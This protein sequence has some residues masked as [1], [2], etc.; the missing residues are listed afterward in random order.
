M[1]LGLGMANPHLTTQVASSTQSPKSI[2]RDMTTERPKRPT[3]HYEESLLANA[4]LNTERAKREAQ[5]GKSNAGL[6][7]EQCNLIYLVLESENNQLKVC[8]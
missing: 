3:V 5:K 1:S 6:L 2:L 4:I 7:L 8:A